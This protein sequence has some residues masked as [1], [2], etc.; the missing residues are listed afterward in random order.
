MIFPGNELSIPFKQT[1][2][3]S[4]L[5]FTMF[6]KWNISISFN[7]QDGEVDF[8]YNSYYYGPN[9]GSDENKDVDGYQ[10]WYYREREQEPRLVQQ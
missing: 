9:N 4:G 6:L 5:G 8:E 10:S 3:L 1:Q 7:N 2:I